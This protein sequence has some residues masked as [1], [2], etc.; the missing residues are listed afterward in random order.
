MVISIDHGNRQIKTI[1]KTF[2]S[3]LVETDV[4]PALGEEFIQYNGQIGRAHV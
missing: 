1:H 3:G 2:V 4:R